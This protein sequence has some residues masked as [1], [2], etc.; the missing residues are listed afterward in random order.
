[1]LPVFVSEEAY[2][3]KPWL[4]VG[5]RLWEA[6]ELAFPRDY[7]LP[8]PTED[9]KAARRTRAVYSDAAGFSRAIL[10][11]L[12]HEDGNALLLPEACSFWREHS[13]RAGLDSW[14]ACLR[15]DEPERAFL[16]RWGAKGSANVYVRTA[17]RVIENIQRVVSQ[18]ARES[19]DDGPDYFG[20]EGLFRDLAAHLR[21][22]SVE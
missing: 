17:A 16:G 3:R 18:Y 22:K 12:H 10:A 1:M 21:A 11:S 8:L 14:A 6:K 4:D 15:V 2:L 9:L 19:L 13:D 5:L 20:E 7:L